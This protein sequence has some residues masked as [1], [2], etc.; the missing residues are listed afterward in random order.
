MRLIFIY[1]ILFSSLS[2]AEPKVIEITNEYIV[3]AKK[4]SSLW[5]ALDSASPIKEDGKK[6]HAHTDTYIDWKYWWTKHSGYC[7]LNRVETTVKITYILPKLKLST[8][9]TKVKN[10]WK[11][12][13]PAV[14]KHEKG[15]ANIAINAAR[16]IEV[17]LIKMGVY[18]NCDELSKKANQKAK[19]ILN[20][21]K[22]QH[23]AYDV[24]TEHGKTQGANLDL[25]I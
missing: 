17:K 12:Y 25:Y 20:K 24:K 9:N 15:H 6:F 18:S 3:I 22:P 23:K 21:Y 2:H 4:P 19:A 7:K 8:R 13:F 16:E 5:P 11:K 14:V 10:I 1:L